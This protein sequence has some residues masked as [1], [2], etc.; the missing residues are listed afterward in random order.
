[1]TK[2]GSNIKVILVNPQKTLSRELASL[3]SGLPNQIK[4]RFLIVGVGALGSQLLMHLIRGG[5][6][7]WVVVDNDCLLPHNVSRHALDGNFVGCSKADA[8]SL[9]G[10]NCLD[11][12]DFIRSIT[13]DIL[14]PGDKKE[15]LDTAYKDAEII[16]DATTSI[17]A[18]RYIACDVDSSARRISVFMNP[19]GNDSV[20]LVE[21]SARKYPLDY[22]E[23]QYY[24]FLYNTPSVH[25][26]LKRIETSIRYGRS[27]R[28]ISFVLSQELV[29]LHS[30]ICARGIRKALEANDAAIT[31][32]RVEDNSSVSKYSVTPSD[33]FIRS[34]GKWTLL[35]DS[36]LINKIQ[37]ARRTKL[38]NETGGVLLG[39]ID[40]QRKRVYAVDTILS[41]PDSKEWP[42]VYIR[43]CTG[44]RA[45]VE[46]V[47]D[48]T[49]GMLDYVGEWHSHPG[50]STNPSRDDLLAFEWLAEIMDV[51]EQ[52]A[53]MLIAGEGNNSFYLGKML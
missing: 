21:D 20:I 8:L 1:M 33:V 44:L 28:D 13:A 6:G 18:A 12:D 16:I 46:K 14:T 48:I 40:L 32:W 4:K 39:T 17:S 36:F 47:K 9:V 22:L 52:P 26:H 11:E 41:P 27:C 15:A 23:M 50:H 31:I 35:F 7:V 25:D 3:I 5:V 43:G 29:G 51:C 2:N 19:I 37:E 53:L 38:P 10:N 49:M 34:F 24:R 30:S 42:T 45:E